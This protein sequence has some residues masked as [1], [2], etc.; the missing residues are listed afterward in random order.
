MISSPFT[1]RGYLLIY[2]TCNTFVIA[3]C[4]Y[5]RDKSAGIFYLRIIISD[6][7]PNFFLFFSFVTFRLF[8]KMAVE[9]LLVLFFGRFCFINEHNRDL[10][11]SFHESINNLKWA[12]AYDVIKKIM[13]TAFVILVRYVS[14]YIPEAFVR[15]GWEAAQC[16]MY[17]H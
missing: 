16:A 8:E 2:F 9:L 11:F 15:K 7:V 1:G 12:Y 13:N 14:K 6:L 3:L 4:H 10:L 5:Y 17:V